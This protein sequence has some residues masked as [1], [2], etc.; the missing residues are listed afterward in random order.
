MKIEEK[1]VGVEIFSSNTNSNKYQIPDYQRPYVWSE[2][3]VE[4][5]FNDLISDEAASLSFLGSFIF[6]KKGDGVYD[7]VDGQQRMITLAILIAVLRDISKKILNKGELSEIEKDRLISFASSLSDRLIDKTSFGETEGYTLKVWSSDEEFFNSFILEGRGIN[8]NRPPKRFLSQ[9]NMYKNY[10][11]LYKQVNNLITQS[12]SAL[13]AFRKINNSI[14]KLRVITI[15]VDSDEEAYTAFEIVNARGQEL[16]NMDLLK[17]LFYKNANANDDLDNMKAKWMEVISNIEDV[18]AV[19]VNTE[20]FLKYFWHSY[21]GGTKFTTSKNLYRNFSNYIRQNGYDSVADDLVKNS[22]IFR[23]FFDL[24]DY[25]W[26]EKQDYNTQILTFLKNIRSFEVTQPYILFMSIIRNEIDPRKVRDIIGATEKFHFAY[27]TISKKQANKVEKLYGKFAEEFENVGTEDAQAVG[28]IYTKFIQ[29]LE[30][31]F[32]GES[33]FMENFKK[34]DYRRS[35]HRN[36]IRYVFQKI[37]LEDTQGATSFNFE[38]NLTN[39][40]HIAAQSGNKNIELESM[41]QIGNILPLSKYIN[42]AAGNASIKDK[43][44]EYYKSNDSIP[45]VKEFVEKLEKNNY[46][47]T[48]D[49]IN[50]RTELLG[51]KIYKITKKLV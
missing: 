46:Q 8:P 40:E 7:I 30:E 3:K 12:E 45:L 1:K 13:V 22:K 15:E 9:F 38:E 17:N 51:K 23:S 4:E 47:W 39:L 2:E 32:P 28:N 48:E 50:Q 41:H 18:S 27:S 26:T 33:E 24:I 11:F 34:I 49:N 6:Q 36:I 14:D 20:S 35:K 42:S 16:G 31:L 5:F 25:N 37:N 10:N 19:K 43:V 44:I 21:F 29:K